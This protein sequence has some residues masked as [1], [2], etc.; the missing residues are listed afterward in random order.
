MSTHNIFIPHYSG[1]VEH[2]HTLKDRLSVGGCDVR[3]SSLEEDKDNKAV[4]N[5]K[6]VSDAVIARYIRM[7]IRWAK[8]VVVILGKHTHERAW[9]NYEIDQA[10]KMGKQIIGIYKWGC[11]DDVIL[12]EAYK[13]YGSSP[14]GWNSID[15]LADLLAGKTVAPELPSGKESGPIYNIIHIKC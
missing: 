1:D 10:H 6:R 13:R 7:G 4:H 5:G 11:K 2:L 12:P 3:N 8:T 14:I 15:K 9:V